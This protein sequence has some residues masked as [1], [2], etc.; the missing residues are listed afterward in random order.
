MEYYL[1]LNNSVVL[2]VNK[3]LNIIINDYFNYLYNFLVFSLSLNNQ[4]VLNN[5]IISNLSIQ[6]K[7]KS[8]FSI[9][10]DEYHFNPFENKFTSK[11]NEFE[12]LSLYKETDSNRSSLLNSRINEIKKLSDQCIKLIKKHN[13][14]KNEANITIKKNKKSELKEITKK[15]LSE[16]ELLELEIKK[17]EERIKQEEID[18]IKAEENMKIADEKLKRRQLEERIKEQKNIFI[19]D[20]NTFKSLKKEMDEGKRKLHS[21]P[22]LF[23]NKYKIYNFMHTVGILDLESND[24]N[25]EEKI[26]KEWII[27]KYIYYETVPNDDHKKTYWQPE[28][29]SLTEEE[30]NILI[31]YGEELLN[32]I[33]IFINNVSFES[34]EE[35]I[36][37]KNP[38]KDKDDVLTELFN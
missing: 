16:I 8:I 7:T 17:E 9:I 3:N 4:F 12:S 5:K 26:R 11:N 24:L 37:K 18:K 30:E 23:I 6:K 2:S 25:E 19:H 31:S 33:E 22:I 27:Y 1:I 32:N 10:I 20:K 14:D 15:E 36:N 28:L 29:T 21:V 35:L 38:E 13:T 34:I